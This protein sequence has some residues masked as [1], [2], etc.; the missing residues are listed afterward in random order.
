MLKFGLESRRE[1]LRG[2]GLLWYAAAAVADD[3]PGG[4]R[5]DRSAAS[6]HIQATLFHWRRY[7]AAKLSWSSNVDLD[8][9]NVFSSTQ[10]PP[11][12]LFFVKPAFNCKCHFGLRI[13]SMCS[14]QPDAEKLKAVQIFSICVS[15]ACKIFRLQKLAPP[16]GLP[17]EWSSHSSKK[18]G[19]WMLYSRCRG[20]P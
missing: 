10:L 20:H 14:V 16:W 19:L 2:G 18:P 12:P 8:D 7:E 9:V 6:S 1:E 3:A 11:S 5:L 13:L 4:A 15:G 17:L